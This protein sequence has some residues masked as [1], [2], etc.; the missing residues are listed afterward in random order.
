[1]QEGEGRQLP[2]NLSI[3]PPQKNPPLTKGELRKKT[4]T[5]EILCQLKETGI[6]LAL[7]AKKIAS[8]YWGKLACSVER[9]RYSIIIKNLLWAIDTVVAKI[10]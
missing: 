10:S 9:N 7:D 1:M 4:F 3:D 5:G 6:P 8:E 2:Y